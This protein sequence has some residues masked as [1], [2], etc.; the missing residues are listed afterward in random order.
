MDLS[1]LKAMRKSAKSNLAQI[2]AALEKQNEKKSYTDDKIW[3]V[4]RDKAGNGSA[5]IRFLPQ[6]PDD[7]LPWVKTFSHGFQGPTGQWYIENCLTTINKED[8]VVNHVNKDI[9]AGR[10]WD[11]L[12]KDV[13]DIARE[14]KRKVAF[15]FNILVI[16]DPKHPENNGQVKVFKC[17]T[18]IYEMIMS[19]IN[20]EFEDMTPVDVF[21]PWEG[22]NFRL[23]M[24]KVDGFANFD[25]SEFEAPSSITEDDEELLEIL[26]S[27][28]RLSQ[29]I[30]P[31]KFKSYEDLE[32]R[33]NLVLS[34]GRQ[35]SRAEDEKLPVKEE[36]KKKSVKEPVKKEVKEAIDEDEED[37]KFFQNLVND[38]DGF[39]P[40]DE[41]PF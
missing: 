33:L 17:G 26:N 11:S 15:Y 4:E 16:D 10:K 37:M 41:I 5:L 31:D 34:G 40:D 2:A 32:A 25:K 8:P 13:Q 30:D 3:A 22:A 9:V 12:P 1:Q 35:Q 19:K 21:N 7:E 14:R 28:F 27:R 18:K 29:Y 23:R 36:T 6:H 20:P 24:R 38:E 39:N